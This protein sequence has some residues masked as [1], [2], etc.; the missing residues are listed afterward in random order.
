MKLLTFFFHFLTS[1]AHSFTVHVYSFKYEGAL[2]SREPTD[3]SAHQGLLSERLPSPAAQ[4]SPWSQS[5]GSQMLDQDFGGAPRGHAWRHQAAR[6]Y[7]PSLEPKWLR[8]VYIFSCVKHSGIVS[9][10]LLS[11]LG[12][13][14]KLSRMIFS[15]VKHNGIISDGRL[16]LA[17]WEGW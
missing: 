4:R 12:G 10:G 13:M 3:G 6:A 5:L 17:C 14:I 15:L 9:D 11:L 1:K 2:P 8:I 7:G 16:S